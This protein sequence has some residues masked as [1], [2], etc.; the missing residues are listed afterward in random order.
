MLI[1]NFGQVVD[2]EHGTGFTS[3]FTVLMPDGTRV[4]VRTDEDTIQQLTALAAGLVPEEVEEG[5]GNSH[6][7]ARYPEVEFVEPRPHL[8]AV[9]DEPE[10]VEF[11]GDYDPGEEAEAPSGGVMGTIAEQR[12]ATHHAPGGLGSPAPQAVPRQPQQAKPRPNIDGDGYLVP[13][14]A[15][16]VPANEMGYPVVAQRGAAGPAIEDDDDDGTQI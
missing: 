7:A 8:Q 15:K 11:G 13:P 14:R 5:G 4:L 6:P 12:V 1:V 2:L 3:Q 9:P 16:T 10:G